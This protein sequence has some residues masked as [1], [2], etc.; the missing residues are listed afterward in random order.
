MPL[1]PWPPEGAAIVPNDLRHALRA[2][3]RSPEFTL[4]AVLTLALGIGAETSIYSVV[5]GV[6]L[7]PLPFAQPDEL[8]TLCETNPEVAGFCIAAPSTVAAWSEQSETLRRIGLGREWPMLWNRPEGP[9][10]VAGGWATPGLFA[11]LG[12]RPELGRLFAAGDVGAAAPKVAL[13]SHEL[14]RDELGAD[15][16]AVGR[17]VTLDGE[18]HRVIGV[19]PAGFEMPRLERV[20]LWVPLPFALRDPENRSWRGF[21]VLG[22]MA[23]RRRAADVA[24]ELTVI[25]GRLGREY[26]DSHA[27]WGVAVEG[28]QDHLVGGVRSTLLL[29]L[30]AVGLVLLVAAANVAHLV[31]A[32]ATARRKDLAVR[33]A[34]GASRAQLTRQALA[35]GGFLSFAAC[36]LGLLFALVGTRAFLGLAPPGIPR[37]DQVRIDPG[38]LAFA[39]LLAGLATLVFGVLPAARLADRPLS[40]LL[41]EVSAGEGPSRA[42]LRGA[43]VVAEVAIAVALLAG[44]GLLVRSFVNLLGWD[45]GF[46]R[47]GLVTVFLF[48]S[49]GKYPRADDVLRAHQADA[50]AVAALPGVR[51]VGMASAGPLFGGRE[52]GKAV[53]VDSVPA[54]GPGTAGGEG[55]AVRW[56]DVGPRYFATLG[57]PVV[58]GRGISEADRRGTPAVA[59][60]NETAA[61]RLWPGEDPVGKLLWMDD[62]GARLEVV[63]IVRDVPPLAA[64][65]PVEPEVYWPYAQFPRWAVFLVI[66]TAG[67]PAL[68]VRAAKARLAELDPDLQTGRWATMGELMG[69]ELRQPRFTLLLVAVFAAVAAALAAIGIYG[70]LSFL[71][72]RRI[73]ELGVRMALGAERR[74]IEAAVVGQALRLGGAGAVLG[75]AG[76]WATARVLRSLLHGVAATDPWTYAAVA[77]VALAVTVLAGWLPARRAG[78]LDPLVAL[79]TE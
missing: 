64:G 53:P 10:G 73:R 51:F 77:L 57:V 69:R 42:R 72:A 11:T 25:E 66:R 36:G 12:V 38:V 15:P 48:S 5:R 35:E 58:R 71:V 44:A 17:L 50:E 59:L 62:A 16:A 45:P 61:R 60:V 52:T 27:G 26:P 78:S 8:V 43:L 76:A 19:L 23:P 4:V 2:L 34:L 75:L 29:F 13:V 68:L 30:A 70:L 47:E 24:S 20:E 63:G 65:D 9:R 37:L 7:R 40:A 6:L 32:R 55:T 79:R 31:L 56:Y 3:A 18:P 14:W 22:R 67:D 1:L 28:L 49:Q 41:H 54:G 74:Q 33:T 21:V 39:L 46:E